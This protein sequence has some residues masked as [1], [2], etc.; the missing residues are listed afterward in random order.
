MIKGSL[1]SW[2]QSHT[3]NLEGK[4]NWQNIAYLVWILKGWS[5]TERK[6]SLGNSILYHLKSFLYQSYILVF[7]GKNLRFIGLGKETLT[8][9]SSME[10]WM[11]EGGQMLSS[12]SWWPVCRW[13]CRCCERCNLWSFSESLHVNWGKMSGY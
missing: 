6:K 4:I 3:Q 9:S 8:T 11:L 7:S 10:L 13:G 5:K 2:H 1:K 12:Q